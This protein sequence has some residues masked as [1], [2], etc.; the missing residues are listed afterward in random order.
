VNVLKPHKRITVDTLLARGVSQHEIERRTGVDRK[1]IR[2][3]ARRM[4]GPNSPGVATGSALGAE[5]IPPLRPPADDGLLEPVAAAISVSACA[6]HRAWIER[7]VGLGRN[8][9]S[10]FQDLVEVMASSI[11]TTPSSDS[12][13]R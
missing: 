9:V 6:A 8:A 10:I 3:C 2:R 4:P 12:S 11:S 13:R 5:Q 1:T 7:Q